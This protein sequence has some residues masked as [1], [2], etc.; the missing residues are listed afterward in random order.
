MTAATVI[1]CPACGTRNRLPRAATGHPRCA[2]CQTDLPWLVEAGD[3]DI[4]E[5]VFS[6]RTPVL[7]DC[8][9]PWCGPCR[10]IAPLLERLAASYAGR[11]KVV[12]LNV[13]EAPGAAARLGVRGIPALFLVRDG[14]VIEQ[15]VGARP[16]PELEA[17]VDRLLAAG[18]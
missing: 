13:D 3:H 17:A 18:H 6:S 11:L 9:A 5:V 2:R 4:D 1:A 14:E 8:W 10:S 12:K 16:L 15:L 7:L